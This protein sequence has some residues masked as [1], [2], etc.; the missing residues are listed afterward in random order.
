MWTNLVPWNQFWFGCVFYRFLSSFTAHIAYHNT[1]FIPKRAFF[2]LPLT[3]AS[4]SLF[5]KSSNLNHTPNKHHSAPHIPLISSLHTLLCPSHVSN[6]R[7]KEQKSVKDTSKP[8]LISRDEICSHLVCLS[9][10]VFC[11]G[12]IWVKYVWKCDWF[13]SEDSGKCGFDGHW[14]NVGMGWHQ[15][16]EERFAVCGN[17]WKENETHCKE[18]AEIES[19]Q[20]EIRNFHRM[21]SQSKSEIDCRSV[22]WL[23]NHFMGHSVRNVWKEWWISVET[24]RDWECGHYFILQSRIGN[25][26]DRS[27]SDTKRPSIHHLFL[28]VEI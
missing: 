21:Q 4:L 23:W 14:R 19:K 1:H 24:N 6:Q 18:S 12:M 28:C 5:G 13:L 25:I 15:R 2:A 20:C 8:K 16:I 9:L 22:E 26:R 3:T 17:A 10:F 27:Q 7:W 11:D